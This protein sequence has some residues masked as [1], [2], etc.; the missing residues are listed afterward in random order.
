VAKNKGP[1]QPPEDYTALSDEE[2]ATFE[3]DATAEF[4]EVTGDPNI[5][6]DGLARATQLADM[7]DTVRGEN[8]RRTQ[9]RA[10]IAAGRE[11]LMA[12]VHV[13]PEEP[14]GGEGDGDTEG[15][16][17]GTEGAGEG[18]AAPAVAVVAT[19][20]ATTQPARRATRKLNL[21]LADAQT[22][23]P[24]IKAPRTEP[25]LVASADIPGFTTGGRLDGMDSLV[26]AMTARARALP[27]AAVRGADEDWERA[28]RYPIAALER[29]FR[30]TL[31]PDAT[32]EQINDVLTAATD[33]EALVAAGGWCAPSEISYDFYNIVCED[34]MIDLPT[35]GINRGG[36]R[37]PVSASFGDLVGN[38][39][40]WS[41]TELQDV[42]A[43]TGTGAGTKTCARVPC[44]S[45]S[46]ERL[47]CDGIC[48]TVGNLTEDAFPELIANHTKLLFAA[49]AHKMNGRYIAKLL[50]ASGTAITGMGAAGSGL[51]APVLGAISL[52]AIDYR[53]KYAMCEDAILE[54]ILPRW[55]RAAMRSDLRKRGGDFRYLTVA[56]A[57]LM[58]MFDVENV[59]VQWVNDW[60]VRTSGFP[61]QST[62]VVIWPTTVQFMIY[63][64]G[65]F[66]L[67]RGLRLNLG[68]IRDSVL[69]ATNDHTAEWQEECWL[70]AKMGH[71]S[72]LYTVPI[73]PDGTTGAADLTA[74]GV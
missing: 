68:V 12:R 57:A 22:H 17:G 11:A 60:Q 36:I 69:N 27:I 55:V 30:Y 61:G 62:P 21:S 34:G 42:A 64:P 28:T 4:D 49:H 51:V 66:V 19:G 6:A 71:E 45:F 25:V 1:V 65:T 33:P 67:G 29:Q 5:N 47:E 26:A 35:I 50:T 16:E 15:G 41:W 40:M 2:L 73:C 63:A 39:A 9:E 8:A 24:K 44:P 53:E 13:Q 20:G 74:C 23:A 52:A 32:L 59:R 48:L 10:D 3:T 54:V 31:G 38:A 14:E 37:F 7:I 18:A 72:R 70:I 46:E 58:D 56:D 43:V